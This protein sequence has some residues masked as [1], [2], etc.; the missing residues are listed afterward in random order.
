ML[1]L[2][3]KCTFRIKY[4]RGSVSEPDAEEVHLL[5]V[6][7]RVAAA[8][9]GPVPGVRPGLNAASV[10]AA[11]AARGLALEPVLGD[12]GVTQEAEWQRPRGQQGQRP[13]LE[14][15]GHVLVKLVQRSVGDATV[16]V[17]RP[18]TLLKGLL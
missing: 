1:A 17:V 6:V 14:A 9:A 10:E 4:S 15:V 12:G 11:L 5:A 8:G 3:H 18:L 16:I 2:K 7:V 13:V